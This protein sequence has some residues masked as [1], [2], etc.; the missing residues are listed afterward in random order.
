VIELL[1]LAAIMVATGGTVYCGIQAYKS[2]RRN[3]D[4]Q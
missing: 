3:K 1:L 2:H 4:G